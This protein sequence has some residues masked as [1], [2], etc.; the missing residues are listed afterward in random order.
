MRLL[1]ALLAGLAL[2]GCDL[3]GRASL[4]AYEDRLAVAGFAENDLRAA[5]ADAEDHDDVVAVQCYGALLAHVERWQRAPRTIG[6]F[7]A[8]QRARTVRRVMED[9]RLNAACAALVGETKGSALRLLRAVGV[10]LP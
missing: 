8:F 1:L 9:E 7:S 2:A 10:G 6:A 3:A 4:A 5:L